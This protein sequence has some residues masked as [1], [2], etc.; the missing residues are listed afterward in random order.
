VKL[1]VSVVELEE[2]PVP[3]AGLIASELLWQPRLQGL[4]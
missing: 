3:A 4:A 2:P 1:R